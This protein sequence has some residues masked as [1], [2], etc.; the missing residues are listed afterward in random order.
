MKKSLI[1]LIVPAV[2]ALTSCS[3]LGNLI[4]N[5]NTPEVEKEYSKNIVKYDG[6]EISKDDFLAA[7][8]NRKT[9]SS[10]DRGY[11]WGLA[12]CETAINDDV[13]VPSTKDNRHELIQYE[14]EENS[15]NQWTWDVWTWGDSAETI[16]KCR[17]SIYLINEPQDIVSSRSKTDTKYYNGKESLTMVH[18][19][20]EEQGSSRYYYRFE[21]KWNKNGDVLAV[22]DFQ[23]SAIE[24]DDKSF[25][26]SIISHHYITYEYKMSSDNA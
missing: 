9:L 13:V 12:Y 24:Q 2:L 4:N 26:E 10:S 8:P 19:Y 18:H 16:E 22:D 7:F 20:K 1:T 6:G 3:F 23:A 5:K 25:V 11:N 14:L 17:T 15:D 21:I